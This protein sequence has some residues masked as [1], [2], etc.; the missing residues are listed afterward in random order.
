MSIYTAQEKEVF[1]K[2]PNHLWEI[3][4]ANPDKPWK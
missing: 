3:I 2:Q 4:H 1:R